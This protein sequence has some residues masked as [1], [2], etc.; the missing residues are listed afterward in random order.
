VGK[1]I[2][3]AR[4]SGYFKSLGRE[5]SAVDTYFELDADG[6]S[7][8]E[9]KAIDQLGQRAA[10]EG[11]TLNLRPFESVYRDYRFTWFDYLATATLILVPAACF[12]LLSLWVWR[13][14]RGGQ[15]AIFSEDSAPG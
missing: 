3:G 7:P 15:R 14:R 4:D 1:R 8:I 11:V 2:F 6:S 10:T 9:F 12:L 13:V 5:S